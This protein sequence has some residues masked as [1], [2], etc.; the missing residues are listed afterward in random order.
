V[1]GAQRERRITEIA[2]GYSNFQNEELHVHDGPWL[3]PESHSDIANTSVLKHLA[4]YCDHTMI[5]DPV[6][7]S[8]SPYASQ[9]AFDLWRNEFA[10]GLRQLIPIADLVR[11]GVFVPSHIP[12]TGSVYCAFAGW[13]PASNPDPYIAWLALNCRSLLDA[14]IDWSIPG[15]PVKTSDDLWMLE[16]SLMSKVLEIYPYEITASELRRIGNLSTWVRHYSLSVVTSNLI[17]AHHLEQSARVLL[18]GMADPSSPSRISSM[19]LAVSYRVPSL[20]NVRFSDIAKLRKNEEIFGEMR[21]ALSTLAE[22]CKRSDTP[23]SY[24]SYKKL[25][26]DKADGI[27]GPVHEKLKRWQRRASAQKLAGIGLGKAVTF[28]INAAAKTGHAPGVG[29]LAGPVGSAVQNTVGK[30]ARSV[31]DDAEIACGIL[32]A[33]MMY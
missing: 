12:T 32:E 25:V 24:S 17:V 27:V 26:G 6:P 8:P 30:R 13:N 19:N 29:R 9:E 22:A 14:E 1:L 7:R 3:E 20:S 10:D 33:I 31:H 16:N 28:G 2:S 15:Y 5:T 21:S 4:L 23:E 11:S 18:D